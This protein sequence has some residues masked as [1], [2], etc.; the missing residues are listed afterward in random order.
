MFRRLSFMAGLTVAV[1]ALACA[2]GSQVPAAAAGWQLTGTFSGAG[3]IGTL[4]Y[5]TVVN[6]TDAWAAGQNGGGSTPG[7]LLVHWDGQSWSPVPVPV[8]LL[9]TDLEAVSG[10][11]WLLGMDANSRFH[12]ERWDGTH[13]A[14]F[15]FPTTVGLTGMTV[16][17]S[18]NVWVFGS[19][20]GNSGTTAFAEHYNGTKW[21][22]ESVPAVP[23]GQA[24][25][26]TSAQNQWVPAVTTASIGANPWQQIWVLMHR[27]AGTWHTVRV[28]RP[29]LPKGEYLK[30]MDV[31]ALSS[32]SVWLDGEVSSDSTDY[33]ISSVLMHW[34]GSGWHTAAS[35]VNGLQSMTSDGSGGIWLAGQISFQYVSA[36]LIDYRGGTWNVQ[37]APAPPGD[38]TLVGELGRI[39]GTTSV[40]GSGQAMSTTGSGAIDGVTFSYGP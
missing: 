35:P 33:P 21:T 32:T 28:P 15:A 23:S 7:S 39:P 29:S 2:V 22:A 27:S 8:S 6:A 26:A 4:D 40:L 24:P 30:P 3:G 37:S 34:N 1:L 25:S 16:F 13:W 19:R 38:F 18:S 5:L 11:V 14:G 10:S 9:P 20:S 36:K 31:L 17:S 12:A